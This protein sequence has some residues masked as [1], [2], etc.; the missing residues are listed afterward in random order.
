MLA[1]HGLSEFHRF[2]PADQQPLFRAPHY[3]NHVAYQFEGYP[4]GQ[5]LFFQQYRHELS[6]YSTEN[7]LSPPKLPWSV[8]YDE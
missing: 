8:F 2:N 3:I 6:I 7:G 5:R 1:L 4:L